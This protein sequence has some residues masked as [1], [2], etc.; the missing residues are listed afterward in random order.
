MELDAERYFERIGWHPPAGAEARTLAENMLQANPDIQFF[1]T[2]NDNE[3]LG[4]GL[5]AFSGI[6]LSLQTGV[7]WLTGFGVLLLHR[8]PEA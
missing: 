7:S 8:D 4:A 1:W 3:A 2:T 5:A 6:M